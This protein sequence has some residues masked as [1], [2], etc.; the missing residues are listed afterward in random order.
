MA[1]EIMSGKGYSYESDLWSVG[2]ILYEFYCGYSP[3]GE[4][5]ED[6]VLIFKEIMA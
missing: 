3:F 6:P 4:G 5:L 2:V 1:P